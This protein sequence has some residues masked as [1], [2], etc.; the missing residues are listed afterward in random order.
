M[1]VQLRHIQSNG[2]DTE[3]VPANE[4]YY[5][6]S[7]KDPPIIINSNSPTIIKTNSPT[8]INS[9]SPTIM[10]SNSPTIMSSNSPSHKLKLTRVLVAEDSSISIATALGH[11]SPHNIFAARQVGLRSRTVDV[12][13]PANVTGDA[14]PILVIVKGYATG[15]AS[16]LADDVGSVVVKTIGTNVTPVP[17]VFHFGATVRVVVH[18]FHTNRIP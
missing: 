7:N 16:L 12:G 9:N 2:V 1:P 8:I 5:S 15:V 14:I 4:C 6:T 18:R 11:V 17:H 13:Q 10:N 3:H